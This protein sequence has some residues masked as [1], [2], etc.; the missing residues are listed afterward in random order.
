MHPQISFYSHLAG[1]LSSFPLQIWRIRKSIIRV[2]KLHVGLSHIFAATSIICHEKLFTVLI[3]HIRCL[4]KNW[5]FLKSVAHKYENEFLLEW[6]CTVISFHPSPLNPSTF[7]NSEWCFV[8]YYGASCW[9]IV[10]ANK[11]ISCFNI[12]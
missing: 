7:V 12:Y 4:F 5:M 10:K 6:V 1:E 2:I 11:R 3:F 9:W 8:K